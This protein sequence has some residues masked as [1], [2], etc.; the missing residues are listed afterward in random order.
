[1]KINTE[2]IQKVFVVTCE[3]SRLDAPFAQKFFNSMQSFIKKGHMDIVLDLSSV[4]FVDSTGLGALVRCLKEIG[5]RGQLVLCGVNEMVLSLLKMTHLDS[6]FTQAA[7]R[8]EA[9]KKLALEKEKKAA[10]PPAPAAG[11]ISSAPSKAKGFNESLLASLSMEDG[12]TAPKADETE[13]RKYRRINN[14]QILNEDIIV[15]CTNIAN[16]RRSTSIVLDISPGGLLLVSPSKLTLGQEFIIDGRIGRNFKFRERAVIRN[17]RDGKYG[18]EFMDLSEKTAL[19]LQ[20]L[21]G[22]VVLS[23]GP[24]F[25]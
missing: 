16:G 12:E 6:I 19:F 1:M 8:S 3:G 22:S 21:T 23:K 24:L 2:I 7:T 11:L 25:Q 15:H 18:L 10:A 20:Q 4:E 13:R 17:C 5:G 9:L 14:K